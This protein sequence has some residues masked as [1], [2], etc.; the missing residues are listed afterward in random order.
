[1]FHV[2]VYEETPAAQNVYDG[3]DAIADPEFSR[4]NNRV[5]FSEPY[6]LIAA[7]AAGADLIRQ[8]LD[9]PSINGI[10]R[11]HFHP[12]NI[13]ADVITDPQVNDYRDY[14]ISL[15]MN[16]E[17]G[18]ETMDSNAAPTQAWTA[19]WIAPP[20]WNMS[21]P[22]GERRLRVRGT[23]TIT[24]VSLS[25]ASPVAIT[26]DEN[27]RGGNYAVVGLEVI[28][29]GACVA[30]L[31]FSSGNAPGGRRLRPGVLVQQA[32]SEIPWAPQQGGLGKFGE[33]HS[34]ELPQIDAF[35]VTGA[36][37]TLVLYMDLVRLS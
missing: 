2:L 20:S 10:A 37:E 14:P 16:E 13:D 17:I 6:N 33:F 11:H 8:R 9:V 25:W 21:L 19:L 28:N 34:F 30:R 3:M 36:A 18:I 31:V 29:T 23:A 35:A 32:E 7:Y 24:T 12:L 26:L 15:P 22:R 27:L 4:R 5:I 1:M